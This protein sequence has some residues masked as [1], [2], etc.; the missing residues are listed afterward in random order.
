MI[1]TTGLAEI[2]L[3][4]RDVAEARRFYEETLG[5]KVISPDLR[6]PVFLQ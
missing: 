4:V 6:G 2:V 3:L 1:R 5:L